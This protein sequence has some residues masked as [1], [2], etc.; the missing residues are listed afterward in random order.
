MEIYTKSKQRKVGNVERTVRT[1]EQTKALTEIMSQSERVNVVRKYVSHRVEYGGENAKKVSGIRGSVNSGPFM[2]K[3]TK[4][5]VLEAAGL[6]NQREDIVSRS[7][8]KLKPSLEVLETTKSSLSFEERKGNQ[9]SESDGLVD[10]EEEK[11]AG[12]AF[13]SISKKMSM[14][15]AKSRQK[16]LRF[17]K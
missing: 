16:N 4:T 10:S 3:K 7:T 14:E 15:E 2:I 8:K 13:A 6:V 5:R 12:F 1:K 17:K 9:E 11:S